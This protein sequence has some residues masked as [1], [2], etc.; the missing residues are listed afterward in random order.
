MPE[1]K[2]PQTPFLTIPFNE[3][4]S[5]GAYV[6]NETGRLYQIPDAA[7][8]EGHSPM[9]SVLGPEGDERV[10]RLSTDPCTPIQKLRL[11]ASQANIQPKF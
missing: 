9:F 4:N 10:T 5:E 2:K 11:L 7:L 3:I 6:A 8:Q 1:P